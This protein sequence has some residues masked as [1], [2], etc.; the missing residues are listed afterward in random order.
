MRLKHTPIQ[1]AAALALLLG[2]A[3]CTHEDTNQ[4]NETKTSKTESSGVPKTK[5]KKARHPASAQ[6]TVSS[7]VSSA[8]ETSVTTEVS[9]TAAAPDQLTTPVAPAPAATPAQ[10]TTKAASDV[11]SSV[12]T[13]R[14]QL[15]EESS[16]TQAY[17][18]RTVNVRKYVEEFQAH[19]N[20]ASQ[21]ASGAQMQVIGAYKQKMIEA[22]EAGGKG[23]D[24][25]AFGELISSVRKVLTDFDRDLAAAK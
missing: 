16:S 20:Q 4:T 3:A 17:G 21:N 13:L 14:Q 25:Q 18:D 5:T 22:A 1:L 19:V 24:D 7:S 15:D 12:S 9:P 2:V 23:L 6:P 11:T 10:Q 8:N